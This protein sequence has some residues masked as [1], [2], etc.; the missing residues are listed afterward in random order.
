MILGVARAVGETAPLIFTAFGSSLMNAN[1]FAGPQMSLPLFIYR[2]LPA[3][4]ADVPLHRAWTGC[5]GADHVVARPVRPRPRLGGR[6]PHGRASFRGRSRG[7]RDG[8]ARRLSEPHVRVHHRTRTARGA[9]THRGLVEAVDVSAWFGDHKVLERVS[10]MMEARKV[11]AL[12]G[13][14]GCGKSTFLRILNRMHELVPGAALRR[15]GAA[16][17]RRHLRR[18]RSGRPIPDAAS[19]WCSR[20]RTRS[21]RCRS[22]TT[23]WRASACRHT[24]VA[25][26]RRPRR[27]VPH[28]RRPVER[29]EEPAQAARRRAVRRPAAA[30]VHRPRPGGAARGAADGRAVLRARPDVDPAHRG[31]DRRDR[32]T[33]SRS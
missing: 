14:S 22:T 7:P 23:C 30:A 28:P 16:R 4:L 26:P 6:D 11:T 33:R 19:A 1:P 31:D 9:G 20:S 29:G 10:L 21:R 24:K 12:I 15:R 27:G 32:V 17:R 8:S 25:R 5:A 3:R 2:R 18:R 13:P